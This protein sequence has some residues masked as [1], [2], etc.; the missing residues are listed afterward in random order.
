MGGG[1]TPDQLR[2]IQGNFPK[3]KKKK[4]KGF[5]IAIEKH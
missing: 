5:S 2:L 4:L 3:K 1:V